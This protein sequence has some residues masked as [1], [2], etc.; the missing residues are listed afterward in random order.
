MKAWIY[1]TV[2]MCRSLSRHTLGPLTN[3]VN[4]L[5]NLHGEG[6]SMNKAY[7]INCPVTSNVPAVISS[8]SESSHL[9]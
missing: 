9:L 6:L 3:V 4:T 8:C 7:L 2:M 1:P 5:L